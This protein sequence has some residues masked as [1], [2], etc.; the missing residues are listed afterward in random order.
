MIAVF[1]EILA[2]V[3]PQST[4]LGG[5]PYNVARHL[6]ALEMD[7]LLISRLGN[8]ALGKQICDDM[9]HRRLS[10]EGIQQDN[11]YPTGQVSVTLHGQQHQFDIL[12]QQAYDYIEAPQALKALQNKP[13]DCMYF[14]SLALRNSVSFN[15]AQSLFKQS[16]CPKFLDLNLRA[17]W[18]KANTLE[19]ALHHAD[20]LKLNDEELTTLAHL[21][22]YSPADAETH[23]K[24]LL[25]QFALKW[26]VVTCGETGA[27][28]INNQD[29]HFT[30][31]G[32]A[33]T[34]PLID[35]VGAGDAFSAVMMLG[36]L[37]QW[38]TQTTLFRANQ[39]ASAICTVL[40]AAP[41]NNGF[42]QNFKSDW[43]LT[44]A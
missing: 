25:H 21:L 19:F 43:Q 6:Q 44:L 40:G 24:Q 10:L 2:D 33:L 12:D 1:G 16:T 5:A 22:G 20:Y 3:F 17:P 11:S 28:L 4:V 13:I 38:D 8:D 42:Y 18:Y 36:I 35:S 7:A 37:K 30:D 9:Q 39:L 29:Q 27:W 31:E 34:A 26:V 32:C 23:A 14:G 41:S 15:T